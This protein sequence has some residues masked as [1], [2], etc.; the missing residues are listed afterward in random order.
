MLNQLDKKEVE[1][2]TNHYYGIHFHNFD[3]DHSISDEFEYVI[4]V[5]GKTYNDEGFR[6]YLVKLIWCDTKCDAHSKS[7]LNSSEFE[8]NTTYPSNRTFRLLDD[9]EAVLYLL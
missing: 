5:T 9:R 2:K 7:L 1:L 4:R 6:I 3:N 8:L